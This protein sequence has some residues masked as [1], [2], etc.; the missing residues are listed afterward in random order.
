MELVSLYFRFE[1]IG[2]Q[3]LFLCQVFRSSLF[4]FTLEPGMDNV[5]FFT[6]RSYTEHLSG[7]TPVNSPTTET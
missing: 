1:T 4:L 5:S 6:N 7:R 3:I 2:T